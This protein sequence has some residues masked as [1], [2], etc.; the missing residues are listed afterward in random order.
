M[1]LLRFEYR[2]GTPLSEWYPKTV[3]IT[4]LFFTVGDG[5]TNLVVVDRR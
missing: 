3:D 4:E 5:L 1:V 2:C